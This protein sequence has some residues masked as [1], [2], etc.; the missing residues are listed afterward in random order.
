MKI[1]SIRYTDNDVNEI[2]GQ[3]RDVASGSGKRKASKVVIQRNPCKTLKIGTWNDRS[4]MKKE[5]LENVK[6]EMERNELNVLGLGE[7]R[8][9]KTA[10][11]T[12]VTS[13][14]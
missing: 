2:S 3:T 4:M 6:I 5:K 1:K 10:V 14:E 13:T 12:G 9:G 7:V 11:I 8:S